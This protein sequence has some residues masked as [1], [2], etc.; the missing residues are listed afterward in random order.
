MADTMKFGPEWL[1]ALADGSQSPGSNPTPST[2]FKLADYRYGHEEML[3]HCQSFYDP[4]AWLRKHPHIFEEETQM[5][6]ALAS[7]S[8]DEERLIAQG[9]NSQVTI[10]P[11]RGA[12]SAA[13]GGRAGLM[14]DRGRGRGGRG[15]GEV[16]AR[17]GLENGDVGVGFGRPRGPNKDGW[18]E[19]GNRKMERGFSR[20]FEEVGRGHPHFSRSMSDNWRDKGPGNDDE[21][22]DWRKPVNR[23][24]WVTRTSWREP[25]RG[26]QGHDLDRREGSAF[27]R[28]RPLEGDDRARRVDVPE[29]IDDGSDDVGSFDASGAFVS[30]KVSTSELSWMSRIRKEPQYSRGS[31]REER[32]DTLQNT[33]DAYQSADRE[34]EGLNHPPR[35][36]DADW[37]SSD[38]SQ[39]LNP[40]SNDSST[41][42]VG[43]SAQGST[44]HSTQRPGSQTSVT[45]DPNIHVPGIHV[46]GIH[47]GGSQGSRED[48]GRGVEGESEATSGA[49]TMTTTVVSSVPSQSLGVELPPQPSE[50]VPPPPAAAGGVTVALKEEVKISAPVVPMTHEN[51][52]KWFYVDPQ[53]NLQGPFTSEDMVQWFNAGYFTMCLKVKRGC[54]HDFQPLGDLMKQWGQV[55]FVPG[56][57]HPPIVKAQPTIASTPQEPPPPPPPTT[58]TTITT[59]PPPAPTPPTPSPPAFPLGQSGG[60]AGGTE[61][62]LMQQQL[63]IQHQILQVQVE[64]RQLQMQTLSQLEEQDTFKALD[65][66]QQQEVRLRYMHS[67]PLLQQRVQ[68]LQQL[69]HMQQHSQQ[70][71]QQLQQMQQQ[72]QQQLQLLSQGPT[73]S[74]LSASVPSLSQPQ[75][76]S[77]PVPPVA[78]ITR[79]S[80]SPSFSLPVSQPPTTTEGQGQGDIPSIWGSA[81]P[82]GGWPLGQPTSVWELENLTAPGPKS[83]LDKIIMEKEIARLMEV[84]RKQ[85]EEELQKQQEELRRQAEALQRDRE[86]M[87]RQK[88]ELERQRIVELQR[89]EERRQQAEDQRRREAEEVEKLKKEEEGAR[90]KI[91]EEQKRREEA[92]ARKR[93]EEERRRNEEERQRNE[94]ELQKREEERR[95]SEEEQR[96]REEERRR[97]EEQ[98][99]RREEE[100]RKLEEE[101]WR[102]QEEIRRKREAE[103]QAMQEMKKMEE[104]RQQQETERQRKRDHDKQQEAEAAQKK[105]QQETERQRKRDHDKQQEAEAAQKKKELERQQQEALRRMQQQQALQNIQLPSSASWARQQQQQQS[106]PSQSRPLAE[107]QQEEEVQQLQLQRERE[108]QQRLQEEQQRVLQQQQQQKTWASNIPAQHSPRVKTLAEIQEEQERQ[109]KQEKQKVQHQQQYQAKAMSLTQAAVWGSGPSLANTPQ[110]SPSPAP[111]P[112]SSP[113]PTPWSRANSIWGVPGGGSAS[114]WGNAN[115]APPPAQKASGKKSAKE[116]NQASSEFPSLHSQQKSNKSKQTAVAKPTANSSSAP[117]KSKKD[118]EA[119]QR[120]FKETTIQNK[121]DFTVWCEAFL[122]GMEVQ[123]DIETFVSFLK[124]VD[125]PYEV[126]DYVKS[127]LGENKKA[128]EFGKQF[129][130]K[131]SHFNNKARKEKQQEEESIWGPAPAVNPREIRGNMVQTSNMDYG[132]TEVG[133]KSKGAKK[134]RRMQKLD[135]ST[136]LGFTVAKDPNRKNAG[137]IESID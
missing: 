27:L 132:F 49:M 11:P 106:I 63:V 122:E 81:P 42:A 116:N 94:E 101:E 25:G 117:S 69:Q 65:P 39:D 114:I 78:D 121:D 110:P 70:T 128:R 23:E 38:G 22:G 48:G 14:V 105:K 68:Q 82:A 55:P 28:H 3:A 134:K 86:I 100:R 53:Q 12:H 7:L 96:R 58:T 4:P 120:L 35:E 72:S 126:H 43:P 112:S 119:V 75:P 125:S 66:T 88:E 5:P 62:L 32:E 113:G 118:E 18:E 90:R 59:L 15:R 98:Q 115:S 17:G 1:R 77:Q 2:K 111:Q 76:P 67:H 9:V 24:R 26:G 129:L 61:S 45:R 104:V 8:E 124:E 83:D 60:G 93:N 99:R 34:D 46:P 6:V 135:G 50:A 80:S 16:Y 36:H 19:V 108:E 37:E 73:L 21:D 123:V 29:W 87:E 131:R 92:E 103:E 41:P 64:I 20:P 74:A 56:P 85:R 84:G 33:G 95:R 30:Y 102:K 127:Y 10:R 40:H 137:E 71:Q 79:S 57:I 31:R 13:R 133:G 107:I 51:G 44:N 91:L 136:L 52:L 89:L 109:L 54:D 130:E 47:G 97:S